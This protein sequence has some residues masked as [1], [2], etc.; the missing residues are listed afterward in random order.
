MHVNNNFSLQIR[1]CLKVTDN[2][3]LL[4]SLEKAHVCQ[5]YSRLHLGCVSQS[6]MFTSQMK[7]E[8]QT[9]SSLTPALSHGGAASVHTGYFK[10]FSPT[11]MTA[12]LPNWLPRVQTLAHLA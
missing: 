4:E 10:T 1:S 12:L 3:H 8:E 5:L 9:G 6:E 7:K 2:Q 11:M